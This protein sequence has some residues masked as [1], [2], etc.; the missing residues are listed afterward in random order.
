MMRQKYTNLANPTNKVAQKHINTPQKWGF[1]ASF[2]RSVNGS[3]SEVVGGEET[4]RRSQS[5]LL[6]IK[7]A[8]WGCKNLAMS[9]KQYDRE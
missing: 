5:K 3:L 1:C 2:S 6:R 8:V 4:A 9:T 7:A